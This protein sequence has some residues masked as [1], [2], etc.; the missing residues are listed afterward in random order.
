VLPAYG[1]GAVMGV[2]P[3]TSA[4]SSLPAVQPAGAVGDRPYGVDYTEALPEAYPGEGILINSAE[5]DGL[6][7][8][9]AILRITDAIEGRGIGSRKVLYRMRDWL[10]SRQRYWGTPIPILYA[11]IAENNRSLMIS[12]QC[13]CL[14]CKIS[15]QMAVAVR[16]WR[17]CPNLS[18]RHAHSAAD[19]L[20]A[21]PIPWVV[22][23]AHPGISCALS[24]LIT[25]ED[26]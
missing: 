19:L 4:T 10:I 24:A 1:S 3:M 9:I 14:K 12:C 11:S 2:P 5:F 13:Y 21:R 18:T 7:S 16:R 26:L 20:N 15:N 23:P 6:P 22:L 8:E 25:R 17:A